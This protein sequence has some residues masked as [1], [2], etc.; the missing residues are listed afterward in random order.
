MSQE[1]QS[2]SLAIADV[3]YNVKEQISDAAYLEIS[4]LLSKLNKEE[5]EQKM[6]EDKYKIELLYPVFTT[7]T[8]FFDED[9]C[10]SEKV[11]GQDFVMSLR[12]LTLETR[13]V[14]CKNN[15]KIHNGFWCFGCK[16]NLNLSCIYFR[17]ITVD[18]EP[19][20]K[21]RTGLRKLEAKELMACLVDEFNTINVI[22][23]IFD[24]QSSLRYINV[25]YSCNCEHNDDEE[26]TENL[27]VSDRVLHMDAPFYLL[28]V[29]KLGE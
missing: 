26:H 29:T 14:S 17:D 4:A 13:V 10:C 18:L 5:Q 20:V 22:Q 1:Q 24:R 16:N 8:T 23:G 15:P 19:T 11:R 27:K 12:P 21:A 2:V 25:E 6:L 7:K 3:L 28:S 9:R